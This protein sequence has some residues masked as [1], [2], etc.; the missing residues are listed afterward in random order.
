MPFVVFILTKGTVLMGRAIALLLLSIFAMT[1]A[2]VG[3]FAFPETT[4][5]L[6]KPLFCAANQT[7]E[8]NF[9]SLRG[10][11]E[12][13]GAF[14]CMSG[15]R[16][17]RDVTAL[18]AVAAATPTLLFG[19]LF[20]L[21]LGVDSA[22]RS[23]ILRDGE[24][25]VGRV[26]DVAF[27]GMRINQQPVYRVSME[28][29]TRD[30]PSYTATVNKRSGYYGIAG[31]QFGVGSL[32][33][34]KIDPRDPQK[35]LVDDNAQLDPLIVKKAG[36]GTASAMPAQATVAMNMVN[37]MLGQFGQ[38]GAVQPAGGTLT[39]RLTELKAALDKG[40]ITAQEYEEQRQ[41]VLKD[42]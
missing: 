6:L 35:M 12:M 1:A 5:P 22:N 26:T 24:T 18:V 17:V 13:S 15:E 33:P 2:I 29:F 31:P 40:L 20:I 19:F 37:E 8:A 34:L 14:I 28:V 42:V 38:S 21:T 41:R 9:L 23:R 30:R 16:V 27:T 39:K 10:G 11:A 32:L 25:G 7:L 4:L 36:G 3:L